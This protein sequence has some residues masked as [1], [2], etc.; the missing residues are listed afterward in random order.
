MATILLIY[1]KDKLQDNALTDK[2]AV[3]VGGSGRD[4]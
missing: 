1:S 4:E 3:S 2:T